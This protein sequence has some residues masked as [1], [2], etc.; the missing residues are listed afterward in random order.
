MVTII[1]NCGIQRF[2]CVPSAI[3]TPHKLPWFAPIKSL[4]I[5]LTPYELHRPWML[6]FAPGLLVARSLHVFWLVFIQRGV[7][8]LLLPNF[9]SA[10]IIENGDASEVVER[11]S[12]IGVGFYIAFVGISAVLVL[13]P[14]E[15]ISTRLSIQRNSSQSGGFGAVPQDEDL[16]ELEFAGRDEDVIALRAEDDPY[17]GFVQCGKTILQEEGPETLLRAWWVTMIMTVLGAFS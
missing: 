1:Q 12:P 9:N 17:Y 13:T 4:Q 15:V 6:Y 10:L 7:R 3:T 14:L 5:L 8:K 11:L 2:T 16:P